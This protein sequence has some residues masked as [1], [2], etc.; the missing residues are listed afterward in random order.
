MRQLLDPVRGCDWDRAQ[1][2]ETIAPYTIEEAF[3]V[4]DAIERGDH[5]ALRGELG[6]LLLQVVFHSAIAEARGLFDFAAVVDAISDKMVRRHPHI[7]AD[8]PPRSW[9]AIKAEERSVDPDPSALSGVARALPALMRAQKIGARAAATG[10]DWPDA[11]GALAKLEEEIAEFRAS[12]NEAARREELG[13][14]LFAVTSVA[15]LS[16]IDAETALREATAK[17]EGRFRAMESTSD[18]FKSLTLEQKDAL[19]QLVKA[20]PSL[21]TAQD[22]GPPDGR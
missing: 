12:P 5:A 14:L 20:I 3:E 11:S 17:F 22:R 9:E 6:D 10:F 19:W 7:F 1:S 2:F 15:R 4:A 18:D 16:G 13:D 21:E 8:E